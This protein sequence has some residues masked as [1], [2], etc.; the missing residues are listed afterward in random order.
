MKHGE[1]AAMLDESETVRRQARVH[2]VLG[3]G[4]HGQ[5]RIRDL[6]VRDHDDVERSRSVHALHTVQFDVAGR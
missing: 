2:P 1:F 5:S 3:H 6:F 4:V